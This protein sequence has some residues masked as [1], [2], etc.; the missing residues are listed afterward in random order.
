MLYAKHISLYTSSQYPLT[1]SDLC[2]LKKIHT[3]HT[4]LVVY[5]LEY[6][7]EGKTVFVYIQLLGLNYD[8]GQELWD[9]SSI[10]ANLWH[11]TPGDLS[12]LQIGFSGWCSPQSW[13]TA[14]REM[15]MERLPELPKRQGVSNVEIKTRWELVGYKAVRE[16]EWQR[17]GDMTCMSE[18]WGYVLLLQER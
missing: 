3:I 2:N 14:Q 16:W 7:W 17:E 15:R 10:N 1:A 4:V 9:R 11:R 8:S 13:R 5:S 12:S 6:S 18:S